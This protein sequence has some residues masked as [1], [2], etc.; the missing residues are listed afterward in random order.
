MVNLSPLAI[1]MPGARRRSPRVRTEVPNLFLAGEAIH[2]PVL[3]IFVPTMERAATS[4]YL[5]AHQI[6]NLAAPHA[7]PRLRIDFQDLT[8]FA[9]LRR[10]DRWLWDR[11]RTHHESLV[12]TGLQ[13]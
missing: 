11:R 10:V 8:P 2:S 12:M 4:G 7:A 3:T 9:F 5:A 1:L 13:S 6:I